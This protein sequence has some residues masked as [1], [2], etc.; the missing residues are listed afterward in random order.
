[1]HF[2][3]KNSTKAKNI[4]M[5]RKK[6]FNLNKFIN[7]YY[8]DQNSAY[9]TVK[10]DDYSDI[11]SK[12]SVDNYEWINKDFA[13]H[14]ELMAYYIPVEEPIVIEITGKKFTDEQKKVI[15]KVIKTYFGLK[16]GDKM[17]LLNENR[18]KYLILLVFGV[19]SFLM[20]YLLFMENIIGTV[21]EVGSLVFWFIM[22]SFADLAF[23]QRN[24]LK[25]DK[26]EAGQLSSAKV[27]FLDQD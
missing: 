13:D 26:L 2:L 17:L 9:I 1:M 10:V 14:L 23:L 6:E 4:Q 12:Y 18:D 15:E 24:N 16:L 8:M 22:W 25:I 7:D 5:F 3:R 11:V 19:L 27:A 21:L 20:F